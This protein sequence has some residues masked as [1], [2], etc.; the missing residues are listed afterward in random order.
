MRV[1]IWVAIFS[2]IWFVTFI[3]FLLETLSSSLLH[4]GPKRV[5]RT[6][7]KQSP[8]LS[9][10][11]WGVNKSKVT[12][13]IY[14]VNLV[15]IVGFPCMQWMHKYFYE[16]I[17]LIKTSFHFDFNLVSCLP[18]PSRQHLCIDLLKQKQTNCE[19]RQ[20]EE[21]FLEIKRRS[22]SFT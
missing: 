21:Y 1:N 10:T 19:I 3:W 8:N 14:F 6:F 9:M 18:C 5:W 22:S 4:A 2:V 20:S 17:K 16:S 7:M 12:A 11:Q 15:L 13:C